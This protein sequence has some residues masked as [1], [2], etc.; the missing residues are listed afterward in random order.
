[1]QEME[2]ELRSLKHVEMFT[3][4]DVERVL[5]CKM[6]SAT[7]H[8]MTRSFNYFRYNT[9]SRRICLKLLYKNIKALL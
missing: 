3:Y 2:L 4:T 9:H 5:L 8:V 1:M 6:I 7:I